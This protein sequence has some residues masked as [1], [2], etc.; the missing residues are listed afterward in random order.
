MQKKSKNSYSEIG[1]AKSE[2]A[3]KIGME[4]TLENNNSPSFRKFLN[5]LQRRIEVA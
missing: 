5:A 2:W 3:D 4:L 1:R